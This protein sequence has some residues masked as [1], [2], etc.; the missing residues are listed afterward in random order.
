MIDNRRTP[1]GQLL[2]ERDYLDESNLQIA[3]T[4][5]KIKHLRL[6][7]ILL[8]L[9]F[10]TEAQLAEALALQVGIEKVDLTQVSIPGDIVALVPADLVNKYMLL[11]LC[12]E[13]GRLAVAM[14]DP[15]MT[16]AVEDLRLVTGVSIRRY[17]ADPLDMENAILR[18]YGSNVA[19]MLDNLVPEG[20]RADI[21]LEN[22]DISADKLQEM[23][24]EPSLVN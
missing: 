1:L 13:N 11:P 4:E 12:Y 14:T 3:L 17:Y 19:R 8:R 22:G 23:A 18:F 15:F 6:G 5:Q 20:T 9:G 24:R 7:E 10:V 21:N 16:E 2:C